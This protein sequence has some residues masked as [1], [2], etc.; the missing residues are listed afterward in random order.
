[1]IDEAAFLQLFPSEPGYRMFLIDTPPGQVGP[2][3]TTWTRSL[4]SAGVEFVPAADRLAAF[5]AVQNTYLG[6]FQLLGGLGL[7]LGS[8]GLGVVVLRNVL[9]RRGEL[10]LLVALGYRRNT[11]RTLVLA[12]HAGLLVSGLALGIGAAWI[13]VLPT[14]LSPASDVPYAMLGLTLGGTLVS[15]WGWT[16][17]ATLGALRGQLLAGLRN[18]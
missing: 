14:I 4:Q 7:V 11:I 12:E 10:A 1:L 3:S 13:A 16:W 15:G 5:N 8:I 18:E 9:E 17:L 2:I 6:T